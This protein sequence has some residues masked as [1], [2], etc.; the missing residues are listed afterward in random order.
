MKNEIVPKPTTRKRL[1]RRLLFLLVM[2]GGVATSSMAGVVIKG[3]VYGGGNAADVMDSTFV[4]ISTGEILGNIYGGGNLGDV[5]TIVKNTTNYNYKWTNEDNPGD[6]YEYNN[7]GVCTVT[8][9]GGTIGTDSTASENHGNVFGGGKGQGDTFWCEKGMTY[10]TSISISQGTVWHNV[11][12][13]GQVGRVEDST[14]VTLSNGADI[15]GDVFGAGAGINTHGYSALV[16]GNTVVTI[17]GNATVGEN[18]YGGG[19]IASIGRFNVVG[20]S[21]TTPAGGGSSKVTIQGSAQIG[22]DVFGSGKGVKPDTTYTYQGKAN[23]PK[24]MMAKSMG[25]FTDADSAY[26]TGVDDKN[27]WEYFA[28]ETIYRDFLRT[29]ALASTPTVT[30]GGNA[31]IAGSVYGG[32]EVGITLGNVN[33]SMTGGTVGHDVYGGGAL[34][35]TNT[36]NWDLNI[37]DD[38]GDS[39]QVGEVITDLFTRTGTAPNYTYK[40]VIDKNATVS[41]GVYYRRVPTWADSTQKSGVF[42]TN[43]SLTGGTITGD[44]YGGGLGQ[45]ARAAEGDLTAL[46]DIEALVYGDV[47]LNIGSGTVNAN[48]F[49][50]STSGDATIHGN[51]FGCNNLNGT[52]KG[53]VHVN[54]YQTKHTEADT[55]PSDIN[56]IAKLNSLFDTVSDYDADDYLS[57]FA[58]SSVYGG[59]NLAAYS[60]IEDTDTATV[61]IY[62]C[63]NTI[64]T[65]YGGGNA[66]DATNV[67]TIIDGGF[68]DRVFGG[69]N[70]YSATN[71]HT[72][73]NEPNYN[74]GANISGS[75]T[76]EIH[77]GLY[78]QAFGGSNQYGD[79]NKASL[80]VVN[81][82]PCELLLINESFGGAN[83]AEITG[84]VETTLA[85]SDHPISIGT[86]YGGSNLADIT[87]NVT[88]NVEGGDFIN[89]FGGSKG[90]LGRDAEGE[91][92]QPGY[93]PAVTAKAA[94]ISGNVTLNLYGGTMNNAF[95]G[96]DVNG[97]IGGKITVN[98]LDRGDCDLTVH[99]VYGG[100]RDAAYRPDTIGAFPE[101]NIL[102]GRVSKKS[103]GTGG[104]VYGGG[105]GATAIVASSPLVII[106]DTAAAHAD[107]VAVVDS[108]VF[109][110]GDAAAVEGNTSVIL[111]KSNSRVDMLFGG[112]NAA[113]VSDSTAVTMT[114]GTVTKAV[115]GG[116]NT[117]GTVGGAP[118][119]TVTGGTIGTAFETTAPTAPDSIPNVLFGGGKGAGTIVSGKITLNVG[120]KTVMSNDTTYIGTAMIHGNVYGG[121]EKG[122]VDSVNVYLYGDTIYGNVYGGGYRTAEGKIAARAVNI[123]LDG[124]KFNRS[125]NGTAQIFGCN[126]LVGTPL[127]QVNVH[128]Y[129]TIPATDGDTY[130]VAAIYGGGNEADYV[131]TA[132]GVLNT[133]VIIEGCDT[134]SIKDVYGGGNAAAVPGTEVWIL[135]S[136][137]IDKV[138]GGGN[139]ER[140]ADSAAHVGFHRDSATEKHNYVI[141]S[142]K[143]EVYLVAGNIN[144]V[145]GGSN[146]NGDIRNGANVETATRTDYTTKF[147]GAPAPDCCDKL[148]T[149]HIYGGGSQAEMSGDVNVILECMPEDYVDAVYGG[150]ANATIN[151]NV[152]LTVTSGKFGRVFGGNNEG[153]SINGTITVNVYE[154]GCDS[155]IIGELYGAGNNA[156]YSIYGCT[157]PAANSPM[158]T[159]WTPDSTAHEGKQPYVSPDTIAVSVN[160]FS[161]TSIGKVYGGGRGET[162]TVI[163]NTH[164]WINML[165]GIIDEH[166]NESI[167]KIGQIFGGGS[168]AHVIGNTRIDVGTA[169]VYNDP[170]SGIKELTGVNIV[171][172]NYLNPTS[173][174]MNNSVTAGIYGGGEAAN[175]DGNTMLN[176][177]TQELS[178]GTNITGNIYGGGLGSGTHVTGNVQVNIGKTVTT[179]GVTSYVGYANITGDVYGGSAMGKV[180]SYLNDSNAETQTTGATTQVNF[181]GG[182]IQDTHTPSGKGNIYGGGLGDNDNAA[183]VYGPV[184]V[185]VYG[186]RA[187]NVFGCNNVNGTPKSTVAVNINDGQVYQSVYGGGNQAI[188][189]GSP[190]VNV[191][192]GIIGT[193][194]D[195]NTVYGGAVYGNVYGGGLGSNGTGTQ[196]DLQKVMAGLVK[197]NTEINISGGTILHNIYGGGAYGSVGT[198]TYESTGVIKNYTSGG[199]ATIYITGGTIGTDGNENGMVFGSSRGDV[200]APDEIHDKLAWVYDARVI[201]GDTTANATVTTSTPLINGSVYGGGENGHNYND[202]LVRINGGTIGI[203][204]GSPITNPDDAEHPYTGAAYPYRG[205]VY[206]GGCGTD[207]YW[208]DADN[209]QTVDDGEK[210]YN[211]LAGIVQGDATITMTGGTVVHNIY[212]A[213]AMGSVGTATAGGVTTISI[214]GG[215]VGVSGTVGGGNVFGAARGDAAAISNEYALVRD[216]TTVNISDGTIYGNVY[217]GGELGCVGRYK[218]TSDMKEFYWTDQA[219]VANQTSY[220]Y[221]ST[222]VCNVTI[223]GGTIGTDSTASENHGNVFGGGKGRSDT[224]WCEKGMVYKTSVSISKGTVW[225]NV[226]GGGQEGRVQDDTEVTIGSASGS[227]EVNIKGDVFGAGAGID[228]HGYSALVRGNPTVTIQGAATKVAENVYGGGEIASVGK[229]LL[230]TEENKDQHPGLAVGMPYTLD[231]TNVGICRVT[232]KDGAEVTGSVFGAGKG[233]NPDSIVNP[234]RMT[235]TGVMEYYNAD[236]Y[237]EHWKDTLLIYVQTLAL[238]TE[239]QVTI[240]SETGTTK[241]KGSVYG[242]SES[243]FVQYHT[244]VQTQGNCEIGTQAASAD[245]YGGGLG[246]EG[247]ASAGRVG[248]NTKVTIGGGTTYG[249]VYGGGAYGIVKQNVEVNVTG[250]E[251]KEDVYGG[252]ALANTNTANW[253]AETKTWAT[254][255]NGA[256]DSTTY[257]TVVNLTGGKIGNAYGGGLGRK[258][259]TAREA[260][261]FTQEECDKYNSSLTGFVT[262]SETNPDT[263][264]NYTQEEAN[265]HN[266]ALVGARKTTDVK[267]PAI[268]AQDEVSE[269]QAMV[270]GDV[271]MTVDGTILHQEPDDQKQS[272]TYTEEGENITKSVTKYGRVFGANNVNG[273]PKGHILVHVKQTVPENG[274]GHVYDKFEIHSV[275]GG[276]NMANYLPAGDS[277]NTHV[278]I[279]DC[280]VTSIQY[281]YGG[282]NSASVPQTDVTV[283]GCFEI[284]MIFG[285]GNGEDPI[286]DASGIWV[287]NPGA[288]VKKSDG[289]AGTGAINAHGGT[290]RWL[291]GGSNKKGLC[292]KINEDLRSTNT[293]CPLK[294]TNVYGAGKNAD[295]EEVFIVAKCPGENVEYLYGGSYNAH[296]K[297]G[298][299]LTLIGGQYKNV[300]GGNDSGGTIGGP[301][302]INIQESLDCAPIVIDNLY[303]G[304]N[305]AEYPG[306]NGTGGSITVNVK[307]CTHI[308]NIFGGGKGQAAVVNGNTTVN[309]N[310]LK[311]VWAGKWAVTGD[312]AT[313]Y[314]DNMD[315][316]KD[317]ATIKAAIEAEIPNIEVFAD[318]IDKTTKKIRCKVKDELGTIGNVFGGGDEA[319]VNGWTMV[320]IGTAKIDSIMR[321]DGNGVPLDVQGDSIYDKEGKLRE[322]KTYNDIAYNKVPVL[323]ARILGDVYGGGNLADVLENTYVNICAKEDTTTHV[324]GSVAFKVDSVTIG[325]NVFGGGKGIAD[326]FYCEKGMVGDVDTNLGNYNNHTDSIRGTHVNIGGGTMEGNVYGGGEV[327]RVEFNTEVTIGYGNG[328]EGEKS[329]IIA[330]NVFAAGKGLN[331]HGYSALVRGNSTLT[332]QGDAKVGQS[333][334]GGG[335]VASVGKYQVVDGMPIALAY[336]NL[337]NC[338]VTVR[339]KAE[340]GPDDMQMPQFTGHVFGAGK[341]ALPYE[342]YTD[343]EKPYQVL[344]TTTVEYL[345]KQTVGDS[346]DTSYIT[347][348]ET[349]A[350]ATKTEVT[351]GG[352]AFVKGSVYGGSENGHVQ[353]DTK[354]RIQ[355]H[356]QIG[357]GYDYNTKKSLPMYDEATV[358]VHPSTTT[359]AT[360]VNE[361]NHWP[362]GKGTTAKYVPYDKYADQYTSYA[363]TTG[364]DG[365]TYYGNVFGGGSGR[366]PYAP[367]KWHWEAGSVG[368][369]AT[370]EISGGHILTNVYGGNELTNVDDTCRV[371]MT[372]GTIGV[373]RTLDSIAVHP[374]TCYL[375]G[376]GKGDQR[377]FFNK[378]TNVKDVIVDVSGGII[379]GSVFGGGEDGHIMRNAK[380]NIKPGAWIGT[381]GTSY[382]DGNVFGGGRGFAG[383]AYTAGNVADS[384]VVNITGG[385][386]LGSI[387]GGGRLG[388]VGYDLVEAGNGRYGQMSD[389]LNRGHVVMNISGGKIGNKYEFTTDTVAAYIP[390]TEFYIENN[391]RRLSHTKGGNVYAGGMG[392]FTKLNGDSIS[393]ANDGIDWTKLGNVKSTKLSISDSTW[394]MGNVYGGGELGAVTD[395]TVIK[396]TGGVIGTE[397][398]AGVPDS[399]T[400]SNGTVQYTYGSIYGGG[401]GMVMHD[402]RDN[403]GGDVANNTH[404]SISGDDTKVRASV[405]GGG[406]M[407]TVGGDTYVDI[408][409]G[410]IGR[411]EVY[412]TNDANQ[413]YVKFGGAT[414]GNVFGGGKG[415]VDHTF[416]GLVKGNTNVDISGGSIYHNVYGGGALGSVGTFMVAK[417]LNYIPDGVPLAPWESGGTARVTITGGTIGI[418]GRDNGMVNGSSRGGI[419]APVSTKLG[420]NYVY[421]DP[422][423]KVA[424]VYDTEVTIGKGGSAGPT[425]KGSVYGGGENGHNAHNALVNVYSGKIGIVDSSDPWYTLT[426]AAAA[427]K[428]KATRGN[429]YGAGCGTDTYTD[430]EGKKHHNLWSG[431]VSVNTEVNVHGGHVKGN[432]YGAGSMGSVGTI[433]SDIDSEA[434]WHKSSDTNVLE[435]ATTFYGFGL[436]WPIEI[437]YVD[438]TGIARVNVADSAIVDGSVYGAARGLVAIE[439][440]DITRHRY[441]EAKFANVRKTEVNI[442][443]TG[444]PQINSSVYGGGEDGHVYED[445]A[446]NIYDGTVAHSVFG[447][448]KGEGTYKATLWVQDPDDPDDTSKHE[449][450]QDSI[451]IHS[452]VAGKVYGN[453]TVTIRGGHVGWFVY[454]GGNLGSVG[455]GN[456]AGGADDYATGG[457]GELPENAGANLW[458]VERD[459]TMAW[460]F[461]NSGVATVNL[462]GGTIGTYEG[463]ES[464]NFDPVDQLPYGSVF[465]GS[466][467][468]SAMDVGQRSPRY[469]YVPDFFLGYVN[470]AIIN[471]GDTANHSTDD[472]GPTIHGSIYGG[473][474]DGHVRNSTDIKLFKGEVKGH[475]IDA[476]GRSGHVF[477]AGS[478][479]GTYIDFTDNNK[480]KVSFAS[481]SVTGTTSIEV[482]DGAKVKGNIW[483]GGAMAAIGP[484]KMGPDEGKMPTDSKKSYSY[485]KVDVK[486]GKIGGTVYGAS[487]GPSAAF[488][489]ARFDDIGV[490]YDSTKYATDI[491]SEVIVRGG[492]IGGSVYGGGESGQVK[493]GVNVN[494]LGGLIKNDVYGGGALAHTNTSNLN[495]DGDWTNS[496]KTTGVYTTTVNLLG[497]TIQGNAYGGALGRREF[498]GTD[499][500]VTSVE[501][502]VFG[503]IKVNLNGIEETDS[504]SIR[505]VKEDVKS[506]LV[507][508]TDGHHQVN[509]TR[510][511]ASVSRVFGCNNLNGSPQGKVRVHVFATQ[512]DSTQNIKTK[513]EKFRKRADYTIDNYS[514]LTAL[515]AAMNIDIFSYVNNLTNTNDDSLQRVALN[516]IID[517]IAVMKYDV[518]GVYGGGNLAAYM[519]LGPN[520]TVEDNYML[521][522]QSTDV[523]IDGCELTSIY[524]VYGGGNAAPV[525]AAHLV[526]NGTYEI[527]EAFGGGNGADSYWVVEGRDTVWYQNPGANVGYRDFTEVVKNDPDYDGE[528]EATAYPQEDVQ[529]A[530]TPEM[531]KAG[532]SYGDESTAGV[533]TTI[534]N[535]GR[536]HVVYGGSNKRGNISTTALSQ[537]EGASDCPME[538][539]ETYGAG[540]DA[541][542]DG[543]IDMRLKCAKGVKEMFGGSKNSDVN[544]DIVLNITNGSSLER[545]FGGNNT[546]GAINGSIT[547]NIVEDGCEPIHIG[548]LYAGGYLAPYSIYGYAQGG[549]GGYL[550]EEIDYGGNIGKI[551]QR[552]PINRTG[553]DTIKVKYEDYLKND[554]DSM[555]FARDHVPTEQELQEKINSTTP[556]VARAALEY[557]AIRDLLASLP[558]KHPRINVISATRIDTIYGGGYQAKVVGNPRVN[559]NMTNGKVE[560]TE[561]ESGKFVDASGNEYPAETVDT[562]M[563]ATLPIGTIGHIFGGGNMADIDGNT[564]VE[565]GTGEWLNQNDQREMQGTITVND[566]D[567]TMLFTYDDSQQKWTYEGK[568]TVFNEEIQK[569]SVITVIK[570]IDTI[571]TP[572]RRAATITGN[573]FGGGRGVADDFY[574]AKAM[575]G[576]NGKAV[577]NDFNDL[578]DYLEGNTS[579]TIANGT[580]G[581]NVYGGGEIGRVEK[582]TTVTIGLEGDTGEPVVKGNVFGA[583]RGLETH[584]YSAL[585]RGNPTVIVQGKAKVGLNVYGGGETASV[586]RYKVVGGSPVALANSTSGNCKVIIRGEA[587]IGPDSMVMTKPGGPDDY[588]HVFGAGKGVIPGDSTYEGIDHMPKRMILRGDDHTDALQGKTWEYVYPDDPTNKNIWEYFPNDST[589][590]SFIETLA[591]SS[592]TDVTIGGHAFVKGSVYGGSE[593]GL[594]QYDTHVRIQDSCQIGNGYVQ[595]ADDGTP[596]ATPMAM[597]RRYTSQEWEEGRLI[598]SD[599]DSL[600]LRNLVVTNNLYQHSLPECASWPYEAPYATY[601]RLADENG[602][603]PDGSN[604]QGGRI[605]ASDGHTFYGN[606]FGGGSGLY[607]FR[608]GKWHRAAGLVRG[609]TVVDVTGG[610]ILTSLYGGNE[611]TDVG[612]YQKDSH[613]ELTIPDTCG[614][615]TIN[616]VGGTLG[617]PR[618]LGQIAAHPVTCY[619]FGAGKGDPR[620]FF[621]TWTNVDSV[622]VNISGNARIYGSTFGGGEDGHI[623][624]S[625]VTNIGLPV[626]LNIDGKDS[627]FT[628]RGVLIGTTGYSYVDGN[629]FGAGRGF[630]GDAITAGSVGG[631]VEVN[632]GGGTMLGSIYGGG[633][634]ASVGIGFNA[635]E[636]A[637]YGSFT[638]DVPGDST[639]T[640]GHVTVNI[641]GG[642]IGHDSI[643][644]QQYGGNVFGGSMGRLTHLDNTVNPI[645]S[646]LGQVKTTEVNITGGTI[647]RNVYGGGE[648]GSVRDS[649]YVNIG[650]R[651]NAD[652]TITAEGSPV[653]E[654]DV[655]GGGYGSKDTLSQTFIT[656]VSGMTFRYTPMQWA[657]IVGISTHVNM[658]GG[659]VKKSI[660]GGGELASVGIINYLV[661]QKADGDYTYFGTVDSLQDKKFSYINI[662]K[663]DNENDG[664]YLSWPYKFEYFPGYDGSTHIAIRGGR[665]GLTGKDFMG[666][667]NAEGKAISLA[668]GHVLDKDEEKAARVDN[669]DIYGGSKGFAGDRYYEG[670]SANVGSTEI[671][672][673]YPETNTAN[674][675]NYK[676]KEG[677]TYANDCI[678]GAVYGGGENGHVLGDTH[679]TLSNG[680]I[681]HALYGGGSGKGQFEQR[682]L[683]V[684]VDPKSTNPKDS[685]TVN[686]YSIT[687]GKVYGNTH[688]DMTGGY[689]VRNIY[690]G[691]NMGSV[692][693]GNY[694]G[695]PD[696]YSSKNSNGGGYGEMITENLWDSVSVNSQAFLNSGQTNVT[697]TGGQV[698]YVDTVK[699]SDSMK[700]GL[701]YGNVFGGCRGESAPNITESP[702]FLY[703]PQFFSGYINKSNVTIGTEGQDNSKAGQKGKAPLILGSVFGGGQDGHVRQDTYVTVNSGQI[704]L[705]LNGMDLDSLNKSQTNLAILGALYKDDN[706]VN[707]QWLYRGNVFGA[708]SGIGQYEFDFNY[709]G[710]TTDSVYYGLKPRTTDSLLVSETG[711]STSAGSVTRFTNVDVK[712][713]VVYRNVYGGGSLASVGPA[714]IPATRIDAWHPE[715]TIANHRDSV[716]WQS[717][718]RV[719]IGGLMV[720]GKVVRP[721]I[722]DAASVNA[723]YGG[724]IFGGGRGELS[725]GDN[726][727][728]S[729]WTKVYIKNGSN[730][731]GNIFGGGDNGTV[732]KDTDVQ[733]GEP[734]NG[735]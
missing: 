454:G 530:A 610:H 306:N 652:G 575:I 99:N 489:K 33:V 288:D 153:G 526:V 522:K 403:H 270:Y 55:Y 44:A 498:I 68:F 227:D 578:P 472:K 680:L 537:Y 685:V 555:G 416:A 19:E 384:V 144:E 423:D 342:G 290:I 546:S 272:V 220:T 262:T 354:V 340:I 214:G 229:H 123:V 5:G 667:F 186:G 585:V 336:Q 263:G 385:T 637:N 485:T 708:G 394:I 196:T 719:T 343:T 331:T 406:E 96:S 662:E 628:E 496:T 686:I 133:Q 579:V 567:T 514:D 121:S 154:E 590:L 617:V 683:K 549:E 715:D 347:F 466:R 655:Y 206:G 145:F 252:G 694:A 531:R 704:G 25:S 609:N 98:M 149:Q 83:E 538:V 618:T 619:L 656:P 592:K 508:T 382:V 499:T 495:K 728:T 623:L 245:I 511:G 461:L 711:Y 122:Q 444:E 284:G 591:L 597:N 386:M 329:P 568:D 602:L 116:C 230:V 350:L 735:D 46:E 725:I 599:D 556:K 677:E 212:G 91:A 653:I 622:T 658:L 648:F 470:K 334:Y 148:I 310:M 543:N 254:G 26:W 582:N 402:K 330:G 380:V 634:L 168:A 67:K 529:A 187:N 152:S 714:K 114:G 235:P 293:D 370:V 612:T 373:P 66:A 258:A 413:G 32:G 233:L 452:M 12:G 80:S 201:I 397:I 422:Y 709:D 269:V 69:G 42:T 505:S 22:G 203:A 705:S 90:R 179:E 175:I 146:S 362:Y 24:R 360:S 171:S 520:P 627:V 477:G 64:H 361:C 128:V 107:Y 223:T 636:D 63:D 36:G 225:R 173:D 65:L 35:D 357:A 687:A 341:G 448:G 247:N 9:T 217:G 581:G 682:L 476:A 510:P 23:M 356:C 707:P 664:F 349:L 118:T 155:L 191:T 176:I 613:G 318:K 524:Q 89:V 484:P 314:I 248:G 507:P 241:V 493:C 620:T 172:G 207:K 301:I 607:P 399:T 317:N 188:M 721:Q 455:K 587:E 289:T 115:F 138:Y 663:H 34:A 443:E 488:R 642:T 560:V 106:G 316:S 624:E 473:G 43:V 101:V 400:H 278:L 424:W 72:N 156:P 16:R 566:K 515:A 541:P 563:V 255:M 256:N 298:I 376:A 110:G 722:G 632:I 608:P 140:G 378:Q 17:Q 8:I 395:S 73:P 167:G 13:G 426:N 459:S 660:Y 503:D 113:G 718:N 209:D 265:T 359:V 3:N 21:P 348:I 554:L 389:N 419:S 532:F 712:G 77:G 31:T 650:G 169:T 396:V 143:A 261:T 103:D 688:I 593:N 226:Y 108:I 542:I 383:D 720:D 506:W 315:T 159:P 237:G 559:V 267:L 639:K 246:I 713:G 533:A 497:G 345:S 570:T 673:D 457:Y 161:C 52:P 539:D 369:N 668:D 45:K 615:C 387:Y 37:Y 408:S 573:V 192:G 690:G 222:G 75:A 242:G 390:S 731:L 483:G 78:R 594:V 733:I 368:G 371:T 228:T 15:K 398:L 523:I 38:D 669:G 268:S 512:N 332:I 51:V 353:H 545:V 320:N 577:D 678:A 367:G 710:D 564:F 516:A 60:P 595:M 6:S 224:F 236:T 616:M 180:N 480:N 79:V 219:L 174:A 344:P 53:S 311:G 689:V 29:L 557:V 54:I 366:E 234:R 449:S 184:A 407:A 71:N 475:Q 338:Y 164:V 166:T 134:T 604:A 216:H 351:V 257:K 552:I 157:P 547:V 671:V 571:P 730:I 95:G 437:Q 120:A 458:T 253:D 232:V 82:S 672:I 703:S 646:Q 124:T 259:V 283:L 189:D 117:S 647:K 249:S 693:K 603:Y 97:N 679:L 415:H 453:T 676:K 626:T 58:L 630:S 414:M 638:A 606:V 518:R 471:V 580:V 183:D 528:T 411:N 131:P 425:I 643:W 734:K 190:V 588:G 440:N 701:P 504:A 335:E 716:G 231:N 182:T 381:W 633:R 47:T 160:V 240:G 276:G 450:T 104:M 654:R 119:V 544:S 640:Y 502:K 467:G 576:E 401:M 572:F 61:H 644:T 328:T 1:L 363:S 439:E 204:S 158:G 681:G 435:T 239:T 199:K 463:P 365:H 300:Y 727:G 494:I 418:S 519:P 364:D 702:R 421:K 94:N 490:T 205:N 150:A 726:Y 698:G 279:E 447:G 501:A 374:V 464:N 109:G 81:D 392:R 706:T 661:E 550:E 337:G 433:I 536:I 391:E 551:K 312:S 74:P 295:V 198:Y 303:G 41:S 308:G 481:G 147:T 621:N 540:K 589:Y 468:K 346:V 277:K 2:Y 379:Y 479:I 700:D 14:K 431:I 323:G 583:G 163:G 635:P 651:K 666:P 629:V 625:V 11:Y 129:R 420:D 238:A 100:G 525:P 327:G 339:G 574:C 141:G 125:F 434:N 430:S 88:L 534:I 319:K 195:G 130:H 292:G 285:G 313:I 76:T 28:T 562:N 393:L 322:G 445:A 565:I 324:Y 62:T 375:F 275:Y 657:G 478:G 404:V 614:I 432:V 460:H 561:T 535:G 729:V 49:A 266:A 200:G 208:I 429:V 409:D 412:T 202:A 355:D 132:D 244:D 264:E 57:R 287:A 641:S 352:D 20:G 659:W 211:P 135:G 696:D 675:G 527:D 112:G 598:M 27:V 210:H 600:A 441:V 178:E 442:G 92:G 427:E 309:L 474:Q 215:S 85:C 611:M 691:G 243:G 438:T 569:D 388:S 517:T 321:H 4:N 325:G 305:R 333:V 102:N 194:N 291:Y 7:T 139:G 304:G 18:V 299:T 631:N 605:S 486:G 213:G 48:G 469:R 151:G 487:R 665:L 601:D 695:A 59:G 548:E 492:E 86:F 294:I 281:V 586:A 724:N 260:V 732:Y 513:Y 271:T 436:S 251:V 111:Q 377:V 302:K 274:G 428:S 177:G 596:L 286:Q 307:S 456:Y 509:S 280:G 93:K 297:K 326:N 218:F 558:R 30:I 165:H 282:G 137:I 197:G 697:V 723:G 462:F 56:T 193:D 170:N 372:G 126:N 692:G 127:G 649:A 84:D 491:W 670:F 221:N 273:T 142:G 70:G 358:F 405:F 40:R 717:L 451:S 521:T 50:T 684:K 465:G 410:K 417:D 446:V 162:A 10:K 181:Y 136:T 699:I 553:Y 500:T 584:G 482:Y 250:G 674:P 39:L 185:N 87:G 296:I 645:W 105:L